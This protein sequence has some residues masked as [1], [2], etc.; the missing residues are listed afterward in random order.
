N[1][2][3]NRVYC[4]MNKLCISFIAGLLLLSCNRDETNYKHFD[5][6]PAT[7]ENLWLRYS[8]DSTVFTLWSPTATGVQ[9]H[10]YD[11]GVGG[12]P[13]ATHPMRKGENGVWKLTLTGDL[14]G[15]YYTY[16]VKTN[17]ALLQET[18]GIYAQAVGLNGSRAMVLN[19]GSTN[20]LG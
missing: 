9:V 5:D 3:P 11:E 8:T 17:D 2:E 7:H 14:Q 20:P 6:Y 12:K 4:E 16:Q 15:S 19:M 1:F 18:P 10:L 13:I